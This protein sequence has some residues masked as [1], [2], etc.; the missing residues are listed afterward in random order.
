MHMTRVRTNTTAR[1]SSS[2]ANC[3][4]TEGDASALQRDSQGPRSIMEP[5][6]DKRV[7]DEIKTPIGGDTCGMHKHCHTNM[8]EVTMQ[9]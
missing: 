4:A 7:I 1:Y 3:L 6:E 9:E 8:Q 2:A 5:M